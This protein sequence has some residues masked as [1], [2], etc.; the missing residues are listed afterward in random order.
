M[1]N[2][3]TAIITTGALLLLICIGQTVALILTYQNQQNVIDDYESQIEQL[4]IQHNVTYERYLE[5]ERKHDRVKGNW[6]HV[7]K[8]I[9]YLET[10]RDEVSLELQ[11]ANLALL[12]TQDA[13]II[14]E[15]LKTKEEKTKF[16]QSVIFRLFAVY[17]EET[18]AYIVE[19]VE[20]SKKGIKKGKE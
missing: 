18:I 3:R 15:D 14:P 5:T 19:L 20:S 12:K 16:V 1:F 17:K 2:L 4:E 7:L 6:Q 9:K 8:Y 13:I 10:S 11:I